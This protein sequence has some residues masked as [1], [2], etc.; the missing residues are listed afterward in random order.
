MT[1]GLPETAREARF[2]TQESLARTL[3]G[4]VPQIIERLEAMEAAGVDN[5]AISVVDAQGARGLI[6]DFGR[7]VIGK[8]A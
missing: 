1:A 6:Q 7:D 5:V 3:T 2:A 8:R 4:T